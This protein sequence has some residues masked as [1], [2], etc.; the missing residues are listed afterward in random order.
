MYRADWECRW[1]SVCIATTIL[2]PAPAD[3]RRGRPYVFGSVYNASK[4]A[5]HQYSNTLRVEMAQ[6]GVRVVT[7]VT[8]GVKSNIARTER[9]LVPGSFYA[10]VEAEYN[11]RV[12]HSQEVGMDTKQYAVSVVRQVTSQG[13][14]TRLFCNPYFIFE[15]TKSWIVWFVMWYMPYRTFVSTATSI[16]CRSNTNCASRMLP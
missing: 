7:I 10:P 14:L 6:F 11:R 16:S 12:R 9:Q 13:I 8:G 3:T 4:A 15:G 2:G 5:L 1:N